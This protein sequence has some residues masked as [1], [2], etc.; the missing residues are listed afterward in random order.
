MKK[1]ANLPGIIHIASIE[2]TNQSEEDAKGQTTTSQ[3]SVDMF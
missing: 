3:P 2:Q 1:Y